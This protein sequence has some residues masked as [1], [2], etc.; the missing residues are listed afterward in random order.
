MLKITCK[1]KHFNVVR[2]AFL[3]SVCTL[4]CLLLDVGKETEF[5]NQYNITGLFMNS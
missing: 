2:Q 3:L 1:H 4:H 5:L